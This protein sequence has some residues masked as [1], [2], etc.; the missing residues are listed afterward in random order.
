MQINPMQGSC[1]IKSD[2]AS[3]T[4]QTLMD[5]AI[6]LV[7]RVVRVYVYSPAKGHNK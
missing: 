5:A 4:R 2:Q 6:S 3:L 7:H 1:A